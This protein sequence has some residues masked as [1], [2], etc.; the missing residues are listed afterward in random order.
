MRAIIAA[1]LLPL[2]ACGNAFSV[3]DDRGG[4]PGSGSGG[5]RSFEVAGFDAVELA[6]NDDVTVRVGGAFAVSATGDPAALDQLKI[7]R[8][9][10]TLK[11]SRRNGRSTG[12][13]RVLVTMPA[14][15]RA[16]LAGSGN[17]S[18]DR[19]AA[20]SFA[21]RILGSGNLDVAALRADEA[22]V[23][24]AGSGNATVTGTTRTLDLSIAG[25]GNVTLAGETDRLGVSIPGSGDVA[26]QRLVARAA[27]VKIM[28]SGSVRA[29]VEGTADV[30]VMGS[31][32]VDLGPRARCSV[33]KMG[34]GNVRCGG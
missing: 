28:G 23:A 32:D 33:R 9:G 29:A 20:R 34:S 24:I 18:I 5:E 25:Q 16:T 7:T 8:D 11:V 12:H 22:E 10:T 19:V 31:G 15:Q 1:A 26:A 3:D 2:A 6:G 13:A 17:L 14:I 21:G 4:I 30:V 27:D